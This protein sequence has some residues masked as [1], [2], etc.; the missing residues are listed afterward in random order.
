MGPVWRVLFRSGLPASAI[1]AASLLVSLG[2]A[3]ALAGGRFALGGWLYIAAGIGDFLDGRIARARGESGPRGAALD[4]IL[5]RYSD[6]AVLA[7]LAWYYRDTWVLAAVLATLIGSMLVSYVRARGEGL[8]IRIRSGMMQRPERIA[9]LGGT[10]TLAPVLAAFTERG[11]ASPIYALTVAGL[12]FLAVTTNLTALRRLLDLL[13]ALDTTGRRAGL[14]RAGLALVTGTLVDFGVVY[15]LVAH[16]GVWPWAATALGCGVGAAVAFALLRNGEAPPGARFAL[17]GAV[18]ALLNA[19]GVAVLLLLPH[20]GWIAAW[21]MA[22]VAV[23]GV[24]NLPLHR[25]Y[26]YGGLPGGAREYAASSGRAP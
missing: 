15:L 3:A 19:G 10:L 24:W 8:G 21:V 11:D 7:G 22:R 2:A 23:L 5:D 18:A 17:V 25:D 9:V 16:G 26:L 1:T 14:V 12:V 20:V 6:T 4:S 13:R